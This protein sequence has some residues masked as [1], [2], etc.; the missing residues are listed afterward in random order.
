MYGW[1]TSRSG[2][3]PPLLRWSLSSVV[4]NGCAAAAPILWE[5]LVELGPLC[6]SQC[7]GKSTRANCSHV[8]WMNGQLFG[9][10]CLG[11]AWTVVTTL[12]ARVGMDCD[13][14]ARKQEVEANFN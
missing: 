11:L 5:R 8:Q 3:T 13:G 9:K 6:M 1:F 4:L 14:E 2:R 7:D 12:G 10:Y